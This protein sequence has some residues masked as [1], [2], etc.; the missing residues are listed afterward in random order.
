MKVRKGSLWIAAVGLWLLAAFLTIGTYEIAGDWLSDIHTGFGRGRDLSLV[1]FLLVGAFLTF[2]VIMSLF[3]L[4]VIRRAFRVSRVL[5]KKTRV[6]GD[7]R[8]CRI[9]GNATVSSSHR[10]SGLGRFLLIVAL[11]TAI[12]VLGNTVAV[13]TILIQEHALGGRGAEFF[14]RAIG[15]LLEQIVLPLVL[16]AVLIGLAGLVERPDRI[17][18]R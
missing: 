7:G 12:V 4:G 13:V 1:A 5:L 14:F 3:A 9:V 8:S 10:P 6:L 15:K 16:V 2:I 11:V 17:D 18:G